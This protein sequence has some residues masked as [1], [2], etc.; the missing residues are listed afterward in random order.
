MAS[1]YSD[2][3][4][5][6]TYIQGSGGDLNPELPDWFQALQKS[7]RFIPKGLERPRPIPAIVNVSNDEFEGHFGHLDFSTDSSFRFKANTTTTFPTFSINVRDGHWK[8]SDNGYRQRKTG[9]QRGTGILITEPDNNTYKEGHQEDDL[10]FDLDIASDFSIGT[11]SELPGDLK[12]RLEG[13]NMSVSSNKTRFGVLKYT[14]KETPH[15]QPVRVYGQA[16]DFRADSLQGQFFSAVCR[17]PTAFIVICKLESNQDA[18]TWEAYE[19]LANHVRTLSAS[20]APM[21]DWNFARSGDYDETMK[22]PFG[23][24]ANN[25][26][27]QLPVADWLR[28]DG[29]DEVSPIYPRIEDPKLR[30]PARK[31]YASLKL[32]VSHIGAALLYERDQDYR[33]MQAIYNPGRQHTVRIVKPGSLDADGHLIWQLHV[34]LNTRGLTGSRVKLWHEN[35]TS[36]TLTVGRNKYTFDGKVSYPPL[37][38]FDFVIMARVT[39][40][41]NHIFREAQDY[42]A[43]IDP[44]YEN[45]DIKRKLDDLARLA[46]DGHP[47]PQVVDSLL[48]VNSRARGLFELSSIIGEPSLDIFSPDFERHTLEVTE[49]RELDRVDRYC[50]AKLNEQQRRFLDACTKQGVPANVAILEGLPRTGKTGTLAL[51]IAKLAICG[52]KVIGTAHSNEATDA[53]YSS[54]VDVLKDQQLDQLMSRVVRVY[55]PKREKYYRRMITGQSSHQLDVPEDCLSRRIYEYVKANPTDVDSEDFLERANAD[56]LCR[57]SSEQQHPAPPRCPFLPSEQSA[58]E[59]CSIH[60]PRPKAVLLRC[61]FSAGV[62]G[63]WHIPYKQGRH[64]CHLSIDQL[65][66]QSRC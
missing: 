50:Q 66:A 51:L 24:F 55:S 59:Q 30:Q 5:D 10:E 43:L 21:N 41:L 61:P 28:H 36:A 52:A 46:T 32:Y 33:E 23:R 42:T 38:G 15:A 12:K 40:R 1:I 53:L 9:K 48:R 3:V 8:Q 2:F 47:S 49:Q 22:Y 31:S 63:G 44:A 56:G 60:Q 20:G 65:A 45:I 18:L 54:V 64:Q 16:N 26:A 17:C 62:R 57:H 7:N 6:E 27:I 37:S 19:W 39:A 35:Q 25:P 58:A 34:R 11:L 4:D 13:V 14:S 29:D